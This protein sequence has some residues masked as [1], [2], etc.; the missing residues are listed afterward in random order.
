M[1]LRQQLK[2]HHVYFDTNIL[3]Y[4]LEGNQQFERQIGELKTLIENRECNISTSDLVFTEVLPPLVRQGDKHRIQY[5]VELLNESN[6]FNLIP[7]SQSICIQAGFLRG[8]LAIKTPDA[9]HIA[10]A[11]EQQCDIFLTND[12][13]IKLPQ[14]MKRLLISEL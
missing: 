8:Q 10:S 9:L 3:I 7:L 4:I 12:K 6:A 2:G 14:E 5:A 11:M 13:G 1:G